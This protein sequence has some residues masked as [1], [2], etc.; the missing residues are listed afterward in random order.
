MAEKE[1]KQEPTRDSLAAD[2][3]PVHTS[4]SGPIHT[5]GPQWSVQRSLG[6]GGP[7]PH[8]LV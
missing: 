8:R 3:G 4:D 2:G 5:A 1:A 6:A 7:V